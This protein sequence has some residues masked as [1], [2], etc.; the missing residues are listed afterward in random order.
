MSEITITPLGRLHCFHCIFVSLMN[1]NALE[2]F[3]RDGLPWH[4]SLIP[5]H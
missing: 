1:V 3:L 4:K 5:R 2:T